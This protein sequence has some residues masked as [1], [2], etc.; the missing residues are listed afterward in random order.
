M[1]KS[2]ED[3][4]KNSILLRSLRVLTSKERKKIYSV[5]VLQVFLGFLD[6][7]GVAIVGLLGALAVTGVGSKQPG[8]RVST[9][10]EFLRIQDES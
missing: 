1:K 7:V 6:L 4:L 8:N 3:I 10:L 9:A 5:V 2:F